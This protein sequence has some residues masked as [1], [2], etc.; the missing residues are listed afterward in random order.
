M[1]IPF[2]FEL[3]IKRPMLR[4]QGEHVIEETDARRNRRLPRPID[5]Q[6][7]RNLRLRRFTFDARLPLLHERKLNSVPRENKPGFD[8]AI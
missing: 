2:A 1:Q 4:H 8:D 6:G 7:E 3:E 5:I